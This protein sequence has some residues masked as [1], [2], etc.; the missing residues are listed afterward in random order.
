MVE[1]ASRYDT[2]TSQ[3]VQFYLEPEGQRVSTRICGSDK[4]DM[5]I[6]CKAMRS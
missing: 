1:H 4:V 3:D 2:A 5:G 6:Q